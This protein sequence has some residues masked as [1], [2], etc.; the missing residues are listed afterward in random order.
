MQQRC[1][2]VRPAVANAPTAATT[3]TT[4][5]GASTTTDRATANPCPSHGPGHWSAAAGAHEARHGQDAAPQRRAHTVRAGKEPDRG[6]GQ[7]RLDPRTDQDG[8][9]ERDVDGVAVGHDEGPGG[10]PCRRGTGRTGRREDRLR[11]VGVAGEDREKP[12]AVRPPFGVEGVE[13]AAYGDP[14]EERCADEQLAAWPRH[15]CGDG[16]SACCG[17]TSRPAGQHRDAAYEGGSR[18]FVLGNILVPG[19]PGLTRR[20]RPSRE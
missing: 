20:S 10:V 13:E 17:A 11:R 6:R 9:G 7:Q 16:T 5:S 3:T 19:S 14:D 12:V 2:G 8:S 4:Y 15:F 18:W 1:R